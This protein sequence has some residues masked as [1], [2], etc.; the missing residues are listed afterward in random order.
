MVI[1]VIQ[2]SVIGDT[3]E[4]CTGIFCLVID[5]KRN[6][7]YLFLRTFSSQ[8][9]VISILV[10]WK[11]KF[12]TNELLAGNGKWYYNS[13]NVYCDFKYSV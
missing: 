5:L 1:P 12:Q 8:A 4:K 11:F 7:F 13:Y 9:N 10:M 6:S 2:W 3:G